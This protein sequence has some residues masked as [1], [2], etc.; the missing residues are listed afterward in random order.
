[1]DVHKAATAVAMVGSFAAVAIAV[2]AV[3]IAADVGDPDPATV[4]DLGELEKQLD[5]IDRDLGEAAD[6]AA[7]SSDDVSGVAGDLDALEREV[8]DL[9]FRLRQKGNTIQR[10]SDN[11]ASLQA[12]GRPGRAVRAKKGKRDS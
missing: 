7:T 4:S 6:A 8:G 10:L 2:V 9:K 1:V 5:S 11:V 3:V 12:P